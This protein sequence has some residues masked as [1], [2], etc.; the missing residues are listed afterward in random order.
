MIVRVYTGED[1][2]SH[3]REFTPDLRKADRGFERSLLE[4]V[5]GV[6][7]SRAPAGH[8][9]DWHPAPR[10]QYVI[11]LSGQVEIGMGDGTVRRFGPGDVFLAEDLTG[12][13][14]TFRVV[15]DQ[16]YLFVTIPLDG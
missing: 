3:C 14:H 11:S 10:R 6:S 13:G 15:G 7:F 1:R 16:P 2:E 12:R 5:K 4:S 8:F 9:L